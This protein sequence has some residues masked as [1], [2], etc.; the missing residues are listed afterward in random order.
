[1]TVD[2]ISMENASVKVRLAHKKNN[3]LCVSINKKNTIIMNNYKHK[4]FAFALFT[5]ICFQ[6]NAVQAYPYPIKIQQPD[7]T[8]LTVIL[9]GDEFNHY[10]T[11]EDGYFI[12][13]DNIGVYNYASLNANGKLTDT[14]L[15]ANDVNYRNEEENLFLSKLPKNQAITNNNNNQKRVIKALSPDM[16]PI[17]KFPKVGTPKSL[18]ILVNFSD[19]SYVTSTPQ[20]AFT[21]LLN[22]TG[23]ST[24]GGT[25][26]ARDYF[27]DNTMGTFNPQF[28]V[29]GPYTLP[30]PVGFYGANDANANDNDINPV[31][32]IVDACTL[33]DKAGVDFT[34]Y[35][36]DNDGIVDNIF[37]YYAGYNEA[38]GAPSNTVWPH[39]WGIYP[40]SIYSSGNYYGNVA[41]V[42][43][44]GKRVEDYACTSE[45]RSYS[46]S[47]MCG[48]GTFVHEF[49]HVL[50][51]ADMYATNG[52]THQTLSYWDVMDAG[53]YLNKGRTP[54]AYSSFERFSLGYM[55][56]TELKEPQDVTLDNLITSN[57]AYIITQN[58]DHNLNG[59]DPNPVEFF[60]LENRQ[61]TS[62]DTY[63]PGHGMLVTHI[64]Y[65]ADAWYN[66]EPNNNP[67]AMGV[68]IVEADNIS[69]DKTLS[70]DPFPGVS[71]I[72]NYI[73]TLRNGVIINK[74]LSNIQESN[75]EISFLF[76]GGK[77]PLV[78]PIANPAQNVKIGSFIPSWLSVNQA[79]G[80]Y[81]TAYSI[82]EGKSIPLT[83][84]FDGGSIQPANGWEIVGSQSTSTKQSG[85]NIPAI[86][87]KNISHYI[88][89][90]EYLLPVV[91]FEFY[92][93]TITSNNGILSIQA[94][95]GTNWE[96]V[97]KSL[98]IADYLAGDTKKYTFDASKNYIRFKINY[99]SN[100]TSQVA[101]DDI[102]VNFAK[103]L[104]FI[105][106]EK[107]LTETSDTLY[108]LVSD[109]DYF[110]KVRA[111]KI[112][113][114]TYF[115]S[116]FSNL[117]KV[118]TLTDSS[119]KTLRTA[120]DNSTNIVTVILPPEETNDL[121]VYDTVGHLV[122]IISA[123]SN[124]LQVTGLRK[125]VV[126]ILKSGK[127]VAKVIVK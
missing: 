43:F 55:T 21:N 35:D 52:G 121:Y 40:T 45:L 10:Q 67:T 28:D 124:R 58:G 20:L 107:Y 34:P 48:I 109:R 87:L 61:K 103:Q 23:Y 4:V 83:Q 96:K 120:I 89:T 88:I 11:T 1:M 73:P 42:T 72:D 41:S 85:A 115:I 91:S 86:L 32:M 22:E 82:S 5:Y 44:D 7:G 60:M 97:E 78:P 108:N 114:S 6:A 104:D 116:D 8:T 79:N 51:L 54:P 65:N 19:V 53:P 29:V 106:H 56:P 66:N 38:E 16:K 15:K 126:Y 113:P 18:V 98:D 75:G 25:G 93:K 101:I 62:W 119:T 2:S 125:G 49:G 47:Q 9:K 63:L 39:R 31:Q 74:P 27:K 92:I 37:V 13:K 110:Y 69:D 81:L 71:Q 57:K 46:G 26:S 64:Y 95:N 112:T 12:K 80:Y 94:W 118:T 117:I 102:T 24:N 105:A 36:T 33:A 100:T 99:T 3:Y 30:N 90:E 17:F 111:S 123:T 70:G 14:K 77:N 50:G 122:Q 76:M 68:D 127:R 59:E 84:S